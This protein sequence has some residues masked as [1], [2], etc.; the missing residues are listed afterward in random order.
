MTDWRTRAACL[1]LDPELFFAHDKEPHKT[2]RAKKYCEECEV[3]TECLDEALTAEGGLAADNRFGVW[4]GLDRIERLTEAVKRGLAEA[5]ESRPRVDATETREDIKVILD[6]G[7]SLRR[8]TT[9]IGAATTTLRTILNSE[10][11]TCLKST[12]DRIKAVAEEG[13]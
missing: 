1:D 10:R 13:V 8:L 2:A 7:M 12:A 3:T 11:P 4:G 6:R 9:L 5:P